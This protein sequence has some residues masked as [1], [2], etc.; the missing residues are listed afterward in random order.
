MWP[1]AVKALAKLLA[2]KDRND[3]TMISVETGG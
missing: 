1:Q 3:K 2:T